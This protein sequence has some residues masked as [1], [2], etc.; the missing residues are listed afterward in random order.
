MITIVRTDSVHPD[1]VNLVKL[2]D[3]DLAVRDGS[4]HSF[5]AQFNKINS[6]KHAVVA[7]RNNS[8]VGC[9]AIKQFN[10]NSAEIKRIY[11]ADSDRGSGIATR[12]INELEDWAKE[13]GYER[14]VL[15]T[16]NNQP[17]AISLYQKLR[18]TRIENYGQYAGVKNSICFEKVLSPGK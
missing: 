4:E 3:L 10:S 5:Y 12:V 13:L 8:P 6:I 17:E 16:G 2:L 15:E 14:C 1:F 18:Y 11:T 7:F 9:G